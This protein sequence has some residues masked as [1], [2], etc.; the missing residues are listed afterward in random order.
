[1]KLTGYARLEGSNEGLRV[2]HLFATFRPQGPLVKVIR[3]HTS[4]K[5]D[6]VFLFLH[7]THLLLH[8]AIQHT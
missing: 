7:H 8:V 3:P 4:R 2:P 1:M 6:I 5:A